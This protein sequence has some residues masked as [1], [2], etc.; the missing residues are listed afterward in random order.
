MYILN[1]V[2]F[3]LWLPVSLLLFS[4]LDPPR[5][6]VATILGAFLLLPVHYTF[7][8]PAV[9]AIGRVSLA[10]LYALVGAIAFAPDRFRAARLG[11]GFDLLLIALVG[12][13][14]CTAWTNPEP[15]QMGVKSLRPMK[16]YDGFSLGVEWFLLFGLP[17]L[18]GRVM[19]RTPRDLKMALLILVGAALVYSILVLWEIRMS[20]RLHDQVYGQDA[21]RWAQAKRF[22]GWRPMVF[23]GHGLALALFVSTAAVAAVGLWR[24]RIRAWGLPSGPVAG[25][26]LVLLVLCKSTAAILYGGAVSLGLILARPR[27]QMRAAAVLAVLVLFYPALR[28]LDLF[29]TGAL[30]Q[31][32]EVIIPDRTNSLQTRFDN[33][34]LLLDHALDKPVFGWGSFGRNKVF[35]EHSYKESLIDGL[36]IITLG[37]F[38][39]VG[40]TAVFGMMLFPVLGMY[41]AF[42]RFKRRSDRGLIA[43][44][45]W[46]VVIQAVDSLPNAML[47]PIAMILAGSLAGV[48]QESGL[49][50]RRKGLPAPVGPDPGTG[51]RGGRPLP[52]EE[53]AGADGPAPQVAIRPLR[54]G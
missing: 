43:L 30:L 23:V 17:F 1:Y 9:P 26:L 41:R 51:A 50:Q 38:G 19:L 42:D 47:G 3:L 45:C 22:G 2:A 39:V 24:L 52:R 18:L 20:P 8:L 35:F 32:T 40:Y 10:S 6:T 16:L 12:G 34:D 54:E 48:L 5:A 7:D 36:W 33:E 31:A 13:A 15:F 46:L 28:A 4:R 53:P 25:Y 49:R 21:A 44:V 14:V 37:E 29:P 11:R 27:L